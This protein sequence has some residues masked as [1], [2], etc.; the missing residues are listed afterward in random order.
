[1]KRNWWPIETILSQVVA[2]I[3]V[4]V[5]INDIFNIVNFLPSGY[6]SNIEI[7]LLGVVLS[8]Q[9]LEVH[10]RVKQGKNIEYLIH[11][12]NSSYFSNLCKKV[13]ENILSVVGEE[14]F[15][16]A[17][18]PVSTALNEKIVAF[19]DARQFLNSYFRALQIHPTEMLLGT[20][21][22]KT[23]DFWLCQETKDRHAQF[24]AK[25]G[26]IKLIFFAQDE[27]EAASPDVADFCQAQRCSGVEVFVASK[28][29][30]HHLH[31]LGHLEKNLIV[32]ASSTVAW[33]AA[34]D[35]KGEIKPGKLIANGVT[36]ERYQRILQSYGRDSDASSK[37]N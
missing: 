27:K 31:A 34:T 6:L 20:A 35:E 1:M 17:L 7:I 15:M 30:N 13:D 16:S 14:Y 8:R 5:D 25:G 29:Y 21:T 9:G 19:E 23:K 36:V 26:R 24:I 32:S 4:L 18:H 2:V 11:R 12:D 22:M 37:A 28:K 33:E 10:Q 3:C